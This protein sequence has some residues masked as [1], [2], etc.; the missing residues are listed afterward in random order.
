[1]VLDIVSRV[2]TIDA[3]A[4]LRGRCPGND[5]SNDVVKEGNKAKKGYSE[6]IIN[7]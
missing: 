6:Q 3:S 7:G 4:H 2:R 5:T 1:M